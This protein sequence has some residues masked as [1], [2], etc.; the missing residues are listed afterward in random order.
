MALSF[1]YLQ[2]GKSALSKGLQHLAGSS[3]DFTSIF[4][5]EFTGDMIEGWFFEGKGF[6][7]SEKHENK[8]FEMI[9]VKIYTISL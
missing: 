5:D 1:K 3:G 4:G 9:N 7:N 8:T 2:L 6:K